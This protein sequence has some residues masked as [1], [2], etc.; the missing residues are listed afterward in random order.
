M[1]DR[2]EALAYDLITGLMRILPFS[3]VSGLGAFIVKMIGPM[4]SKHHIAETGLRLA[5]P[6]K[7]A[8]PIVK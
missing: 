2:F 8:S 1:K 5:F 4:T 3:F 6:D 7:F